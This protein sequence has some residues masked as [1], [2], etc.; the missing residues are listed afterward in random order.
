MI[1]RAEMTSA[2]PRNHAFFGFTPVRTVVALAGAALFAAC[3]SEP[4]AEISLR[5]EWTPIAP[6]GE[7]FC[8]QAL[9]RVDAYMA[10]QFATPF[11]LPAAR[12]DQGPRYG[13]TVVVGALQE[14]IDGMNSFAL[15]DYNSN[16]HHDF[17]NLMTL[18]DYDDGINPRPYLAESWEVAED[19]TSVTFHLRQDVFWHDGEQTVAEDV[20]FTFLRAGDPDTGFPNAAFWDRYLDGEAGVEV[21]DRF[22]VRF[23]MEPHADFLDPWR[24]L[25]IMPEHLLGDVPASELSQHPYGS[26]CPVGNGPF[27][28]REHRINDQWTFQANPDFPQALGGR[29]YADR[30]VYRVIPEETTLMTELLTGNLDVWIQVPPDQAARVDQSDAADLRAYT[31]RNVVFVA[32]NGRRETLSDARVRRALTL[33]VNR[34]ELVGALL[35]GYG[36]VANGTVPPFHWAFD[37]T[38]AAADAF[39]PD[40]AGALLDAAGWTDRNGDGIRE[41]AGGE[42]LVI[43]LTYNEGNQQREDIAEILQSQLARI[44]VALEPE[45]LEIPTLMGRVFDPE[46]RDFDGLVLGWVTEFKLDDRDLFSSRRLMQPY[47]FAGLQN[48]QIDDLLEELQNTTD[49]AAA[50]PLWQEYQRLLREQHP[51]TF[52]FF[53][54]RLAA[55]SSRINGAQMD[56]RGEW[57]NLRDWWIDPTARR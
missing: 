18:I 4:A 42:P 38:M 14:L 43:G 5:H 24:T 22:T 13:G 2:A 57:I 1:R 39:D 49:R 44:G 19:G 41:N 48:A 27:V 29:P 34:E 8:A 45:V 3:G 26:E 36:E 21:L 16:Q 51:Y 37:P 10:E 33:G 40:Q 25:A 56:V 52:L 31:F 46:V 50:T 54:Q 28:F 53:P 55:V 17:I 20:A 9:A 30:Y 7:S 47:A 23:N 15:S 12:S 11:A 35:Q 32:W 6:A